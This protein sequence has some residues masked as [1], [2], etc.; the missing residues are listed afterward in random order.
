M[1]TRLRE[2]LISLGTILIGV[3]ALF[4][5]AAIENLQREAVGPDLVPVIVAWL[6]VILGVIMGIQGLLFPGKER[7]SGPPV[8]RQGMML[9]ATIIGLGFL[10]LLLFVAVGYLVSTIAALAAILVLFGTRQP[11]PVAV[12]SV[13][14]GGVYFLVFVRL[15]G[16]YDPPGSLIDL[17]RLL[18]F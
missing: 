16:I 2:I 18:A 9:N 3:F 6:I 7:P 8:T 14:G 17:S 13:A 11:L 15:M 12:M 5:A 4:Q 1:T 10:Y